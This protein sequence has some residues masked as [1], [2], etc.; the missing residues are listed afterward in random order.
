MK[1]QTVILNSVLA[2]TALGLVAFGVTSL[3]DSGTAA[4]T[5]T[6]TTVQTGNV[7]QTVSATGNAVAADDLTLNFNGS[8]GV[9]TE[10]D[11]KAGDTVT[12]GQ[13]LA[14]VDATTAQNQLKTAQANLT[15]AQARMGGL[16]HPLTAQDL[17]KNQASVAQSQAAVDSAQ[18][19]LDNANANLAQDTIMQEA[20][21]AK[22]KQSAANAQ[23]VSSTGS[24]SQQSNLDQAQATLTDAV[25]HLPAGVIV[26]TADGASAYADSTALVETYKADQSICDVVNS[27]TYTTPDGLT[28]AQVATDLN[29]ATQVQT[30][31]RGVVTAENQVASSNAQAKQSLDNAQ[32]AITDAT[33]AQAATL[34]KDQ[35]AIV[36]AQRQLET[37][38]TS[39]QSTIA[40]NAAA[41]SPATASDIAQQQA[42]IVTAQIAVAT[43]QKAVSDAT[44]VAPAAG[45]ISAVNGQVGEAVAS[46]G[47]TGFITLVDLN[48]LEV[49]AAFSETDAAKVATGQPASVSFDALTG[50]SFT[51]K[52]VAIDSASTVTSN[53]VTYNVTVALDSP[54]PEVKVG[55]TASV[56]VTVA[57]RDGVLE[58]PASAISGRGETATVTVR[59]A[60][61]DEQRQITIG[62]RGDDS[63]EIA[64]GLS[65]GDVVVTKVAETTGT[66]ANA[67]TFGRG[68]RVGGGGPGGAFVVSGGS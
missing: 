58:L 59:T 8:G 61:G 29:A 60:N 23:A 49:K 62:L 50:Q 47:T 33:N 12:A 51:G 13:V 54:P 36:T 42:S 28:C 7:T 19:A 56:D 5:E 64:S 32:S 2:V 31:A 10:V 46:G 27:T 40:S 39:L 65:A 67:N 34:M 17:I 26:S 55:M 16:L 30:A 66:N 63:V 52:V 45:T 20:A 22:A 68:A 48:S 18:A 11:V 9:L 43:A 35:Q 25:S 44:L 6:L 53:V 21:V 1:R 57:E 38:Q 24:A 4:A 14:R 37:A 41:A 15:S 3:G